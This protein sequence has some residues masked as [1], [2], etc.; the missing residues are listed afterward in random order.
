M[1]AAMTPDSDGWA[2][3]PGDGGARLPAF[4]SDRTTTPL[5]GERQDLSRIVFEIKKR[6]R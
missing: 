3:G 5:A 1:P 2:M 6:R 4:D